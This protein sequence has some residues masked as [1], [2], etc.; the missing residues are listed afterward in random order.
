MPGI[1]SARYGN[2]HPVDI[3]RIP[4]PFRVKIQAVKDIKNTEKWNILPW[5]TVIVSVNI[6][7]KRFTLRKKTYQAVSGQHHNL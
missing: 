6:K 2:R 5:F 4:F 7:I 3:R 1:R